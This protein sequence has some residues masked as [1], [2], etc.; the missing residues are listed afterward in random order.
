MANTSSSS[1]SMPIGGITA[2]EGAFDGIVSVL[3]LFIEVCEVALFSDV[4]KRL[5]GLVSFFPN[6]YAIENRNIPD[7]QTDLQLPTPQYPL[8][9]VDV[10]VLPFFV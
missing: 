6:Y 8:N 9:C 10:E 5:N 1:A 3:L 2:I 4:C 7:Q